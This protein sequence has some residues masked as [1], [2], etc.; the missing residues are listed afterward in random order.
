MHVVIDSYFSSFLNDLKIFLNRRL[1]LIVPLTQHNSLCSET[2][3]IMHNLKRS[4]K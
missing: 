1:S 4:I 3:I 2:H